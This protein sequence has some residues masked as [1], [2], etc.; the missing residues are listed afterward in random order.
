MALKVMT[1][2]GTRPE[3][4]KLSRVIYELD[5]STRQILV[6]TGQNYDHEL[7]EIFFQQLDL[8]KP[9]HVLTVASDRVAQT[10]AN[11]IVS[12][13]KVLE[14]EKPDA[15]LVLGDTNSCLSAIAAKRRQVPVFHLEAG[16]RC[17]DERVPE[18][19]NRRIIDHISD[20]N[21]AYTE[22]ARRYL[23]AEGIR[24][25]TV[26]KIGSPMREVLAFYRP[27]IDASQILESLRLAPQEYLVASVHR[28]ENI[29]PEVAFASI[30][31]CLNRIA[32][33]FN[34]RVIVSTHPRT[35]KRMQES[36]TAGLDPRI[37]FAK[38]MGFLDYVKLQQSA[39]CVVSDSGTI[40]EECSILGFPAVMIRETHERPEGV[41]AGALVMAGLAPDRV[42]ESIELV[43]RQVRSGDF[44]ACSVP[45]Y[46][47]DQVSK[48]VVR[49]LLSYTDFVN[50][51]TWRK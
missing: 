16:N 27:G 25:E 36:G 48:K 33:H 45:D 41:D 26:F 8:R 17:F 24:P 51:R 46:A 35:R 43:T 37:D 23:L 28:E 31:H 15:F 7:N 49:I 32:V 13:D 22:H 38:P 9:D 18:E 12:T 11:I 4:I 14:T 39:F 3:V 44:A 1:V 47:A 50:R 19:I 40:T 2:V 21:L 5:Q 29:D 6:H 30:L 42:V 20:I 10:I 34:M